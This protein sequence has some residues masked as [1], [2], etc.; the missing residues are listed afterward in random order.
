M[1]DLREKKKVKKRIKSKIKG[2]GGCNKRRGV[3]RK[4]KQV[5]GL[6]RRSWRV[7]LEG[8]NRFLVRFRWVNRFS[9]SIYMLY[10][11]FFLIFHLSFSLFTHFLS[12]FSIF[13]FS[14]PIGEWV[15]EG[16][17]CGGRRAI[18]AAPPRQS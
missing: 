6:K 5:N 12:S 13:F 11:R 16:F 1:R 4:W 14:S 8:E 18:A 9:L 3:C 15:A 17:R 7:G 10:G 2:S